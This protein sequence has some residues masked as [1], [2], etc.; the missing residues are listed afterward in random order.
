MSLIL[1]IDTAIA[2]ASVCLSDDGKVIDM[3]HNDQPKDHAGWLQPA[4]QNVLEKNNFSAKDLKA[5]AVTIG[6]GSYTGLRVGLA[7]AKGLC[8]ALNIPLITVNTL[9]L[10][11]S[12]IRDRAE[13]WII[14][15]I[16]ARRMEVFTAM[17]DSEL[18]E[19]ISPYS[20]ILEPGIFSNW[21]NSGKIIFC[22]NAVNKLRSV[23]LPHDNAT[24]LESSA[25][26][27]HLARLSGS[28]FALKNFADLA[29]VEPLYVKD[30]YSIQG[31]N[32]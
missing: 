32:T 22:G 29:Y 26:A 14:P 27:I 24:F 18:R 12:S 3:L 19:K 11:A 30:F 4:I 17:Y 20:T 9:L 8:F 5:I 21:L 15:L 1:N 23:L 31:K 7:S 25:N 10:L 2:S 13:E 16:D 6:P 28:L